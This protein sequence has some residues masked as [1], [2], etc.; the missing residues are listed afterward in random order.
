M[1]QYQQFKVGELFNPNKTSYPEGCHFNLDNSG[2]NLILSYNQPTNT[3]LHNFK[4]G[5]LKIG[6]YTHHHKDYNHI[7][8]LFKFGTEN[9]IDTPYS[10]HLSLQAQPDFILNPINDNTTGYSLIIFLIDS[11]SGILKTMR[12]V[13]IPNVISQELYNQIQ[14]Q[15]VQ[16]FDKL[17][18]DKMLN[19]IYNKYSTNHLVNYSTCADV[20]D[21]I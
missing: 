8:L 3:E 9:W 15:R 20:I 10:F 5:K 12:L 13:T 7:F 6:I 1:I 21:T 17:Q 14:L 19:N 16:I 4:L 2:A 11:T 18:Y